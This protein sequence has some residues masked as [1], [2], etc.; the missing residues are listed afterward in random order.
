MLNTPLAGH[1]KSTR[2]HRWQPFGLSSRTRC[3]SSWKV[4][5]RTYVPYCSCIYNFLSHPNN[6]FSRIKKSTITIH[7]QK[8]PTLSNPVTSFNYRAITMH[9]A[10]VTH[11]GSAPAYIET[12]TPELPS[13]DSNLVQIKVVAAG[14]HQV[15]RA[16]AR[17]TGIHYSAKTLPHTLASTA[18][19]LH[20]QASKSTSP[21]STS[22]SAHSPKSLMCP[23]K[24]SVAPGRRGCGASRS[25]YESYALIMDG[26]PQKYRKLAEGFFS[27]DSWSDICEWEDRYRH[28]TSSWR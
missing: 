5:Q 9:A 10:Q 4:P 16:R 20:H 1:E 12:P 21:P 27:L 25:G 28:R 22:P 23:K 17:A 7:N 26:S 8:S 2:L 6:E 18:W 19:V 13:R 14:L 24:T 15:V 3:P 11:W